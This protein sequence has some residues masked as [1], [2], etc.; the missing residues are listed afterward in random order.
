MAK[1]MNKWTPLVRL[2]RGY[3]DESITDTADVVGC[4]RNTMGTYLQHPETMRVKDLCTVLKLYEVPA[5]EAAH[6]IAG[7]LK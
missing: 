1:S 3:Q 2:I 5:G 4:C 6:V 7:C